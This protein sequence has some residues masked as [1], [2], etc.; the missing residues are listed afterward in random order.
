[1]NGVIA[2][3]GQAGGRK[4]QMIFQLIIPIAC[5]ILILYSIFR[6]KYKRK[7]LGNIIMKVKLSAIYYLWIIVVILAWVFISYR[8]I[9]RFNGFDL[10][11]ASN[12]ETFSLILAMELVYLLAGI[13]GCISI[14]VSREIREKG[15]TLAGWIINYS[16]IRGIHWLNEKKIQLNYDPGVVY[17]F[18]R[19]FKVKWVI[20]DNQ[21]ADL[22]QIFQ[23]KYYD[24]F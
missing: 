21:I 6:D 8:L 4:T 11:I 16:D 14:I 22:K 24:S 15:I 23:E 20:N 7:H 10:S 13:K 2:L 18:N 3:S 12:L 19:Q 1:V 9:I 17:I 5:S